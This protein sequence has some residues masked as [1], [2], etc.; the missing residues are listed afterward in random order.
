MIDDHPISSI[1]SDEEPDPESE[2]IMSRVSQSSPVRRER[3]RSRRI[4]S[5]DEDDEPGHEGQVG[6][7]GRSVHVR[8][9][10]KRRISIGSNTDT[11]SQGHTD[12]ENRSRADT[13]SE[14]EA[15]DWTPSPPSQRVRARPALSDSHRRPSSSRRAAVSARAAAKKYVVL[16]DEED[17]EFDPDKGSE[18]GSDADGRLE[19]AF[20]RQYRKEL[21]A[22]SEGTEED[23]GY[24]DDP[25]EGEAEEEI[26]ELGT[27]FQVYDEEDVAADVVVDTDPAMG[28]ADEEDDVARAIRYAE[29]MESELEPDHYQVEEDEYGDMDDFFAGIDPDALI[30]SS[31]TDL[32]PQLFKGDA[33]SNGVSAALKPATSDDVFNSPPPPVKRYHPN[34]HAK[35]SGTA[36]APPSSGPSAASRSLPLSA[37]L[38]TLD[39]PISATSASATGAKGSAQSK[40][41]KGKAEGKATTTTATDDPSSSPTAAAIQ[42]AKDGFIRVSIMPPRE[43]EFYGNHWRR[44]QEGVAKAPMR[45]TD[46]ARKR[47]EAVGAMLVYEGDDTGIGEAEGEFGDEIDWDDVELSG[48]QG[49]QNP[50]AVPAYNH[51]PWG[52]SSRSTG[53]AKKSAPRTSAAGTTKRKSASST[54][55]TLLQKTQK[56]TYED[57]FDFDGDEDLLGPQGRDSSKGRGRGRGGG[58]WGRGGWAKRGAAKKRGAARAKK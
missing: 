23:D 55:T 43:A 13:M 36:P 28:T 44:G 5:P 19:S 48:P 25:D 7:S 30:S 27:A 58:G 12:K 21:A 34:S 18:D 32:Q 50:G 10:K 33:A 54:Q 39:T 51:A 49:P 14:E 17:G 38:E 22:E 57:E 2:A 53:P 45:L 52:T 35:S 42:A 8:S 1:I 9:A 47:A 6:S 29:A 56:E 46:A 11:A 15:V 26:M 4:I 40:S 20:E 37:L 24:D 16:S 31:A 3:G 41:A